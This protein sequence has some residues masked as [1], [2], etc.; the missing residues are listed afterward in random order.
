MI[1]WFVDTLRS[2]P[3][4]A[5]FLSLAIGFSIG[6]RKIAGFSLGNVTATLLAAVV[7]G[8]LGITISP[9]VKAAFFILFI[10]AIGYGVGPQFMSGLSKEG[11]RQIGFSLVV[12]AL[13]L[14]APLLCARLA[15]LDLGYTAGLYAGSQTISASIGV[16][17]DQI[18]RLGLS[19]EQVKT[20]NDQI[21]IG[22]AFTYIFGTIGSAIILAQL[23]PK[24]IGVDL[25]KA[26]KDYEAELGGGTSPEAGLTSAYRAIELRAYRV[27]Q[28]R[29]VVGLPVREIWPGLRVFVE[30]LRR[31]PT[32]IEADADTVLEAG[33]IVAISGRRELLVETINPILQEVQDRE[34]LDLP[35]EFVDVFVTNRQISGKTLQDLSGS[36]WGRGVYLRKIMRNMV[37]IPVLPGTQILRGDILTLV[38]SRR[39]VELAIKRL[40]YPD[41]AVETTDVAFLG[42]GIVL[43]GLVGALSYKIGGIPISLSTTGG[44]L[45]AGLVLGWLRTIRPVFGR[46]PGPAL[47]L[48]NTLGLNVFIAVVGITAGPGFVA[49]LREVG[50]TLF[51]WGAVATAVPLILSVYIGRYI[52]KFHPAILFG[53]CAGARTTT[54]ALGMIQEAAKSK[55]PALGYGMP[56][57]IGNTVLTIYGMAI[58]LLST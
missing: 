12:L 18:A 49:G 31:G 5:I 1:G 53:A 48:M 35:A 42:A 9:N 39:H 45:L 25:V 22:Y 30:R 50:L 33:D 38:G 11:P 21:P 7:I 16:A 43:G 36:E 23:G 32:I 17:S 10:F 8:Q 20:Y 58:V 41:R 54:A 52:F 51:L 37:E 6:S 2:Y 3:E 34:L 4:L 27:S 15:G 46:I 55:I 19:P 44:A 56:Y 40:G 28:D 29:T 47:W 57:A 26:C 13:C 14:I 24:L